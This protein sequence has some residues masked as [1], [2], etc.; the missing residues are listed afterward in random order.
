VAPVRPLKIG[1]RQVLTEG[2][3]GKVFGLH[4]EK[5]RGRAG[6]PSVDS[7]QC[8]IG[9]LLLLRNVNLEP[10]LCQRRNPPASGAL[11]NLYSL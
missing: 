1:S 11:L 5:S 8:G 6:E 7:T 4:H 10:V 9:Y 2:F 3:R